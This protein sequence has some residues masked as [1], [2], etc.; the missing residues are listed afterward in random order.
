MAVARQAVASKE[1]DARCRRV[2][3]G[4]VAFSMDNTGWLNDAA[5]SL[6]EL[7][8]TLEALKTLFP[9][10]FPDPR[11]YSTGGGAAAADP[12][13]GAAPRAVGPAA[14]LGSSSLLIAPL[15]AVVVVGVLASVV[16]ILKKSLGVL[17]KMG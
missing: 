16:E 4:T 9:D 7:Q 11:V 1:C 2:L 8:S 17:N 12:R 10:L 15:L 14:A 3:S 6:G 5:Q 13:G